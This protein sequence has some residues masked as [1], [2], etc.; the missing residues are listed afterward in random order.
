M[1]TGV[2]EVTAKGDV[3]HLSAGNAPLTRLVPDSKP[4]AY[5]RILE[6]FI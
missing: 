1:L 5:E 6:M 3:Y 4:P 2:A